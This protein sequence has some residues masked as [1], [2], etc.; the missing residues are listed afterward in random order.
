MKKTVFICQPFGIGDILFIQ[1]IILHFASAGYHVVVPIIDSLDWMRYYLIPHPDVEYP[2]IKRNG[3]KWSGN[4]KHAGLYV[5][6]YA[7]AF[8]ELDNPVYNVPLL[9][10]DGDPEEGF[11]FVALNT[12]GDRLQKKLMPAKYEFLGLDFSDWA[13]YV[14]LKRRTEVEREL[15]YDVLGL[16]D[17]SRYTLVNQYSSRSAV[18]ISV[19]GNLVELTKREGFT[20]FDW[21]LVIERAAQIVTIDTSLVLLAEIMKLRQ[22]LYMISR[23]DPPSFDEVKDILRLDWTLVPTPADLKVNP[24]I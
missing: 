21:S 24:V 17:D 15:Y 4:F 2:T 8:F 14:H 13:D 5:Q 7:G 23:Y 9:Y 22:P 18:P 20:L 10:K 16:K 3:G 12:S 1:K 6:M 11:M 19:P